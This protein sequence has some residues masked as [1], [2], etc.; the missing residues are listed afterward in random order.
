MK[1]ADN[2]QQNH[3]CASSLKRNW[4]IFHVRLFNQLNYLLLGALL[5][6]WACSGLNYRF[7]LYEN[8]FIIILKLVSILH[9]KP[10]RKAR[11][12]RL[13]ESVDWIF[14]EGHGIWIGEISNSAGPRVASEVAAEL[15]SPVIM[16]VKVGDRACVE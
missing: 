10:F 15:V 5:R 3:I 13:G 11:H 16:G 8:V 4:T 7:R 6:W 9:S 14:S 1:Y 2:L 12:T